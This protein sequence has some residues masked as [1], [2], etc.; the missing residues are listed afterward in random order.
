L[1]TQAGDGAVRPD[2]AGFRR[3]CSIQELDKLIV[4]QPFVMAGIS[5]GG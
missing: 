1:S 3:I 4:G 2:W 5:R